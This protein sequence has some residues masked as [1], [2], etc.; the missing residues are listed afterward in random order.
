VEYGFSIRENLF[1]VPVTNR[2]GNSGDNSGPVYGL[3]PLEG[4][5]L[6]A[7][8]QVFLFVGINLFIKIIT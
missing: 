7:R 6:L 2:D 3:P 1:Y 5:C 4:S 8:F